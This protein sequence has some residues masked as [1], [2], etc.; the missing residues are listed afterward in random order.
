MLRSV[1]ARA[2]DVRRI[3]ATEGLVVALARLA[4]RRPARLPARARAWSGSTGEAVGLDIAFVFPL[5]L[6]RDRARRHGRPRAARDAR[7]AAARGALQARGGAALCLKLLDR[8]GLA[9]PP[10]AVRGRAHARPTAAARAETLVFRLAHGRRGA[11]GAR[12]RVLA[13]R[14][15]HRASATTSRAGWC[16]SRSR[17][18]SRSRTRGCDAG[19]RAVAALTAGPLMIIAGV[20]D[21]AR[22]VAVDRLAGDD[23]TAILAGVAGVVLGRARRGRAVAL[24][25]T[26]RAAAAALPAAGARRGRRGGRGPLRG[27]AGRASR[28]SPTTRRAHRWRTRRPRAAV[29]RRR[30]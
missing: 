27:H 29:R 15:R 16:P 28:S 14:A 20:V 2:R 12:R 18:C 6:R 23:V 17:R 1:G 24:A 13:P 7:A 9:A 22:H 3:F 8:H 19:A 4:A 21:G 10:V 26:R 5:G 30:R 25:P 11:V